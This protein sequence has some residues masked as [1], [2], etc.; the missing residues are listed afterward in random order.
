MN[1]GFDKIVRRRVLK[2]VYKCI[3]V[4][5]ERIRGTLWFYGDSGDDGL[6]E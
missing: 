4:A 5:F 1:W 2:C 6:V 3:N